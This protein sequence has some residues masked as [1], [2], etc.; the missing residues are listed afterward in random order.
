MLEAYENQEVPFEKVVDNTVKHRDASRSPLFQ[1]MFILQNTPDV[2]EVR[3]DEVKILQESGLRQSTSLFDLTITI[4]EA[5]HGLTIGVEYC[6][7]LYKA[8]TIARMVT[9][10]ETILSS[11]TSDPKQ[12]ISG[13]QILDNNEQHQLLTVF[14]KEAYFPADGNILDLIENR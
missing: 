13:F 1:V 11:I 8:E 2:P 12:K 7:D 6:T 4:A 5:A 9:H 10:F 14:N 3:L